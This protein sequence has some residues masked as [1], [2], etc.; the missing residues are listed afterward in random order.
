MAQQG[1]FPLHWGLARQCIDHGLTIPGLS[2]TREHHTFPKLPWPKRIGWPSLPSSKLT[3]CA[4]SRGADALSSVICMP[5]LKDA[6]LCHCRSEK[7]SAPV[8][9]AAIR[10]AP[11]AMATASRT[12][13]AC[14]ADVQ[15]P[16]DEVSL[17]SRFTG[18]L[19]IMMISQSG[20]L[21]GEMSPLNPGWDGGDHLRNASSCTRTIP[22]S[23]PMESA[24]VFSK[25]YIKGDF[26]QVMDSTQSYVILSRAATPLPWPMGFS[27]S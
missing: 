15:Q 12:I 18:T 26:K 19:T 20:H 17:P 6:L 7:Y 23:E 10:R 1:M 22:C 8:N 21:G 24:A 5:L 2:M 16:C 11:T 4:V 14:Q 3:D 27:N 9:A 25:T 13:Q